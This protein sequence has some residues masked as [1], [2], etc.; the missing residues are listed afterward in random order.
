[1]SQLALSEKQKYDEVWKHAEYRMYSPGFAYSKVA[2]QSLNM[3]EGQSLLDAGAGTCRAS[4][5]F[6]E[7]GLEVV[8]VDH[9]PSA[10][11]HPDINFV[12]A[13]LWNLPKEVKKKDYVF[14]CDVME[15]IPTLHVDEVL[16]QLASRARMG[17]FFRIGTAPDTL[18]KK[19]IGAKLHMTVKSAEWWQR[20]LQ[21][22]FHKVQ[23]IGKTN[24]SVSFRCTMKGVK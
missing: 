14:C 4:A 18:G 10:N 11:E 3:Q 23:Q 21:T 16:R 2:F 8:A 7:Q 1:M 12:E 24:K 15:H 13:C 6:A 5:W 9:S 22:K 19:L 20:R 17:A